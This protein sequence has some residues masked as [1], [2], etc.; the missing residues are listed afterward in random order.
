MNITEIEKNVQRIV[1]NFSQDSF[2]YELLEAYGKPKSS[3][4]RLRKGTYNLSKNPDEIIWKNFLP[5]MQTDI[6][7]ESKDD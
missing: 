2:I 7:I 6:T 4:T 5:K 1:N 3:I